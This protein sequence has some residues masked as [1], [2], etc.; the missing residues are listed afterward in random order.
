MGVLH[1]NGLY[2]SIQNVK[3]LTKKCT[4][5]RKRKNIISSFYKCRNYW[6]SQCKKCFRERVK[7]WMLRK[8]GTTNQRKIPKYASQIRERDKQYQKKKRARLQGYK[9]EEYRKWREKNPEAYEAHKK[10][11]SIRKKIKRLPCYKCG[12]IYK[13]HGHHPDYSKP[14][15]VIWVCSI[16][17]KEI[18]KPTNNKNQKL[19]K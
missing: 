1:S 18:H 15:E 3:G 2:V 9:T 12:E 5:C 10:F 13:V 4:L 7:I 17:H 8:F 6:H 19:N 11:N 16:H 14:F